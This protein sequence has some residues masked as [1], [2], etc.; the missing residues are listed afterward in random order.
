MGSSS[1]KTDGSYTILD[2]QDPSVV[3]TGSWKVGGTSHEYEDTVTSSTTVGDFYVLTFNGTSVSVYGTLDSTS[4]GV[5][6][7]Y[8][9]DGGTATTV[10]TTA[11][12]ADAYQQLFF[13]SQPLALGVHELKVTMAKVNVAA[14]AD[15]GTIWFDYFN[16]TQNDAAAGGTSAATS[17]SSAA[18][19]AS[20]ASSASL[21]SASNS[22]TGV[23]TS[24]PT[25]NSIT[26][27]P[28]T[29][30]TTT[31][32]SSSSS[33]TTAADVLTAKKSSNAGVVGGIIGAIVVVL[34]VAGAYFFY[35][36]RR[37]QREDEDI[38]FPSHGS[39]MNPTTPQPFL[40]LNSR[41][42]TP[43]SSVTAF[44]NFDPRQ[45]YATPM[46]PM[47]PMPQQMGAMPPM[48]YPMAPMGHP[49]APAG[50]PMAPAGYPMTPMD[51]SMAPMGH[52][53]GPM[54]PQM[55]P[56]VPM[57]QPPLPSRPQS[58]YD[59]YSNIGAS[60]AGMAPSTYAPSSYAPSIAPTA[61]SSAG[62]L[63]GPLSVV[64]GETVDGDSVAELKRRQKM[65]VESYEKQGSSDYQGQAP[66]Q[67][68]D[69]GLRG[70]SIAGEQAELPPVYTPQ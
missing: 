70:D 34:L 45:T 57:A 26:Q 11:T 61:T 6:T 13:A 4:G 68:M 10:T 35:R 41:P 54:A 53:M 32:S 18:S 7:N 36:R 49:M 25:A 65:M 21:S 15:E 20:S 14:G 47:A 62:G 55:G 46:G 59:P 12:K 50:H 27:T 1:S 5:E 48:A 58:E 44:N 43:M 9:I 51:H 42:N 30:F 17:G 37:R 2:D 56:A 16:V 8:Q 60:M 29:S 64:G 38:Y 33:S 66:L 22:L 28:T 24:Q 52:S 31:S 23:T 69:S 63:R 67:H 39:G 40:Q 3:Y 19:S